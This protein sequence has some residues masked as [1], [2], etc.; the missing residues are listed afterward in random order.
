MEQSPT[1]KLWVGNLIRLVFY[2]MLF[3]RAEKEGDWCV[4]F[5]A[6]GLQ[7]Y[8]HY[9]LYYLHG[10]EKLPAPILSKFIQE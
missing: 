10:M 2:M 1:S 8:A 7:N 5:F 4:T 9:R 6:S 3:V